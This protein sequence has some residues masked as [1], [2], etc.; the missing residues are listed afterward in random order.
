M[1]VARS[2]EGEITAAARPWSVAFASW[3]ASA[4]VALPLVHEPVNHSHGKDRG[5][6]LGSCKSG[7]ERREERLRGVERRETE[8][9]F[10]LGPTG[11]S[12]REEAPSVP[13]RVDLCL[14]GELEDA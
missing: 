12:G 2:A 11:V 7:F 13:L 10:H 1:A 5:T 9:A 8:R 3:T 4:S 6:A 14:P